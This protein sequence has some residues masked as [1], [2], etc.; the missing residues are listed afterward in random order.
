MRERE[1][2]RLWGLVGQLTLAERMRLRETL[3][4]QSSPDEVVS[5]IEGGAGEQ[6]LLARVQ[7]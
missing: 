2:K 1:L 3:F 4:G 7:N 5:V 6:R